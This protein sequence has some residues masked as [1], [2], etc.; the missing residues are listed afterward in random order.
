MVARRRPHAEAASSRKPATTPEQVGDFSL[1]LETAP[2]EAKSAE[3]LPGIAAAWQY[4]PRW[5]PLR[6]EVVIEVRFDHVTGD[7]FRHGTKLV[8]WRPDKAPRQ[9]T[10]AQIKA[11]LAEVGL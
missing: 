6:P 1:P 2:M 3:R 10:F 7:R 9:C 8:C 5:E 11:P 4:E